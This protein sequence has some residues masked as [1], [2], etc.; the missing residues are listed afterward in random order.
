VDNV[1]KVWT[2]K[3]DTIVHARGIDAL[4]FELFVDN[5]DNN[6]IK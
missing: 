3:N 4:G 2:T 5:V 1:D 6:I